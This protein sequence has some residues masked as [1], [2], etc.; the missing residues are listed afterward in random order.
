MSTRFKVYAS[1]A[2]SPLHTETATNAVQYTVGAENAFE[3]LGEANKCARRS[4]I[5]IK[6]FK[7]FEI[8]EQNTND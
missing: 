3:A 4:G 2:Y 8:T 7:Y 5:D 6:A 1:M